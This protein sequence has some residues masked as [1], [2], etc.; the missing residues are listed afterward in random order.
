VTGDKKRYRVVSCHPS[1]HQLIIASND[2]LAGETPAVQE[3]K[4]I[5][6]TGPPRSPAGER[7]ARLETQI[8][9]L[10]QSSA[11]THADLREHI[12]W[13]RRCY[14]QQS[15]RIGN[16]EKSSEQTRIHLKWMK[17][18]WLTVQ[19]GVLGWLGMK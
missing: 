8:E 9:Q 7:L 18:I 1:L 19:A 15:S 12:I 4:M 3:K 6:G 13:Q 5:S 10:L 16:L 11:Q 2:A 14:E 17:A